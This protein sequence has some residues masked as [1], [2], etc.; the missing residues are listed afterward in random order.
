MFAG[1]PPGD[2]DII[3]PTGIHGA[4]TTG[5]LTMATKV[6]LTTTIMRTIVIGIITGTIGITISITAIC[7]LTLRRFMPE[8]E[9]VTTGQPT[10]ART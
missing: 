5:I 3:H 7:G 10:P 2:G 9:G 8:S 1:I 6:I 4:P